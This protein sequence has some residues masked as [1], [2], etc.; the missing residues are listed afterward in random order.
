MLKCDHSTNGIVI[1]MIKNLIHSRN[2]RTKYAYHVIIRPRFVLYIFI[3]CK[4]FEDKSAIIFWSK[5][6]QIC[7]RRRNIVR[8]S[9]IIVN[10]W[11]VRQLN[12]WLSDSNIFSYPIEIWKWPACIQHTVFQLISVREFRRSYLLINYFLMLFQ[13][14]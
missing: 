14:F 10:K 6:K 8:Y 12:V 9:V 2:S 5:T 13:Y 7:H 3:H 4:I 1:Q 11:T